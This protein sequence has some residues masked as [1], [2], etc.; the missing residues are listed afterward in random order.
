MHE[1]VQAVAQ[2]GKDIDIL[3]SFCP[4]KDG[5]E[6]HEHS[7][8]IARRAARL[9]GQTVLP[10]LYRLSPLRIADL[11]ELRLKW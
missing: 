8:S 2:K 5:A 9:R 11:L 4:Q 3:T 10:S 7:T 1:I 6:T